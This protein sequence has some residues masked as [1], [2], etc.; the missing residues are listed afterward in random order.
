MRGERGE[1]GERRGKTVEARGEKDGDGEE[2]DRDVGRK[3]QQKIA[4]L[5]RGDLSV[6]GLNKMWANVMYEKASRDVHDGNQCIRR[7]G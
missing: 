6:V 4:D 1:R 5:A 2:K 7:G 3:T